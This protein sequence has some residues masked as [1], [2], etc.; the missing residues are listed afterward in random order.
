MLVKNSYRIEKSIDVMIDKVCIK[1]NIVKSHAVKKLIQLGLEVYFNENKSS[2]SEK[3]ETKF[4]ELQNNF[5]K[6]MQDLS[7]QIKAVDLKS[8]RMNIFLTDLAKDIFQ[9]NDKF[10]SFNKGVLGK[11]DDYKKELKLIPQFGLIVLKYMKDIS[12]KNVPIQFYSEIEK[13]YSAMM[14]EK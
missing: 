6:K 13:T 9:D 8:F 4:D 14:N 7:T 5:Q 1:E 10:I 11:L 3:I 2:E 12:N